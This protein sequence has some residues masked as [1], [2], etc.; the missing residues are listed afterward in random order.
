M[1]LE[2]SLGILPNALILS[3]EQLIIFFN[4]INKLGKRRPEMLKLETFVTQ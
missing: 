4:R 1:T 3:D 2:F